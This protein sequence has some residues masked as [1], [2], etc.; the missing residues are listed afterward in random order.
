M[1]SAET[2]SEQRD[3]LLGTIGRQMD[4]IGRGVFLITPGPHCDWCEAASILS[5]GPR[6][7]PVPFSP[8]PRAGTGGDF[9]RTDQEKEGRVVTLFFP[10]DQDQRDAAVSELDRERFW[11][12]AGAGTG[13]NASSHRS[14][15]RAHPWKRNSRGPVCVA[16]TFTKKAAEEMRERLEARLRDVIA[17]APDA[18]RFDLPAFFPRTGTVG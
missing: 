16:L 4:L 6:H 15:G 18:D 17:G 1:L 11:I 2:W 13:E 5:Q 9:R 8:R 14:L 12:L 7:L 3:A 10:P